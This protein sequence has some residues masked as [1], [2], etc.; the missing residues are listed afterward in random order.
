MLPRLGR[1]RGLGGLPRVRGG[2]YYVLRVCT[3]QYI[4]Y[5]AK[6]VPSYTAAG[7][8]GLRAAFESTNGD[9]LTN[10]EA[11]L[12]PP[13]GT[14]ADPY[15]CLG[16]KNAK[17]VQDCLELYMND[18]GIDFIEEGVFERFTDLKYL[19]LARNNLTELSNLDSNF[20][21]HCY[22]S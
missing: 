13:A 5:L 9:R 21:L 16:T 8:P 14:A 19:W 2:G 6:A 12:L 15:A 7:A 11:T 1:K 20:R 22:R 18:R 10:M 4:I 3:Y 17:H